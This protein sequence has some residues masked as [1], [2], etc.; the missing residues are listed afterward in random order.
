MTKRLLLLS[1][2]AILAVVCSHATGWG[3]IAMFRWTD[4]YS[5]VAVPNYDQVGSLPYY[6]LVVLSRLGAFAV[7]AFLFVSG[8]FIAY[9][10]RGKQSG[11]SWRVLGVRLR[12][13][14]VPYLIWS[15]AIFVGDA[16]QGILYTPLQY[17]EKLLLGRAHAAYFF[18]PLLCQFYLLSPLIVPL[19]RTRWKLLLIASATLQLGV[20]ALRHL[21]VFGVETP[22][23][24]PATDLSFPMY[25]FY[26][27]S[28]VVGGLHLQPF[29][30]WLTR[31]RWHLLIALVVL[32]ILTV[33]ESE[34]VYR[35]TGLRRGAGAT[36]IPA[37][38]YSAAFVFCMLAFHEFRLPFSQRLYRLGTMSYGI[39]LT[40]PSVLEFSARALKKIVPGLLA[41]Q[42][43]FLH[44]LIGLGMGVPLLLM[45][46]VAK[47]PARKYYS[48]LFG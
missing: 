7:P 36:T 13:L 18:V 2:L 11:P 12:N 23:L 20:L 3:F 15:V 17:L 39:Y 22:G 1:G 34:A 6:L 35:S 37:S 31:Y 26:F 48:Y 30:Q 19:A 29:K 46:A 42:V 16:L 33:V 27:V 24:Q 40:H 45:T 5:P 4:S 25:T 41:Y 14:L 38:L 8:F 9:A 44:L 47:S 21:P 28:G 43:L 10:V 32:G